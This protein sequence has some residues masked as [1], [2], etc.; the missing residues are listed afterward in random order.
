[1]PYATIAQRRVRG[2]HA[3]A[4]HRG[5]FPMPV[6]IFASPGGSHQAAR[7]GQWG[8]SGDF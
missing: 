5:V 3:P 6:T 1:M 2:H 4:G 8:N 7:K